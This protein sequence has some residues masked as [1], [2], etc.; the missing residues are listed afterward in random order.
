MDETVERRNEDND[1]N[2]DSEENESEEEE[3]RRKEEERDNELQ[4][5]LVDKEVKEPEEFGNEEKVPEST[6][7]EDNWETEEEIEEIAD[8]L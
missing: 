7:D 3:R 6:T 2:D 4:Q 1:Q 5:T 8:Y